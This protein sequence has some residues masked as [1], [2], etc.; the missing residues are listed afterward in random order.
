MSQAAAR[1]PIQEFVQ[2]AAVH[3]RKTE[4]YFGWMILVGVL[5][6]SILS[7]VLI[8]HWVWEFNQP[9]RF[10]LWIGLAA[11]SLWWFF[12]RV[13]PPMRYKI[14]PEYAARQFEL[15][16]PRSKDSLISWIQLNQAANTAPKSVLNFVGRYAFGFLRNSDASQVADNANLIRL[17]AACFGCLLCTMIYFFASPKSGLTSAARML[18]PWANIAPATRVQFANITPGAT[19]IMQGGSLPID[20]TVKG[21]HKNEKVFLRYDLSDGQSRGQTIPLKEEIQGISY[22]LDFGKDLGG[23]HQPLTYWI[24]AGDAVAGP[25]DVG[26]QIV[27]LVAIDHVDLTFPAYTNLKPR[28]IQQQGHFEAPE[29]TIAKIHAIANQEMH[30]A[31]IEFDPVLQNKLFISAR[32]FLDMKV[33]KTQLEATWVATLDRN[34]SIDKKITNYRIHAVNGLKESNHDPVLYQIKVI[35]DLPPEI[36]FSGNAN[37]TIDVPVDQ[38][39]LV[40]LTARDPDYGLTAVEIQG[41]VENKLNPQEPKVLFRELLFQS[42]LENPRTKNSEFVFIPKS[43]QLKPGDQIDLIAVASDNYHN[44]IS[45]KLDP[46]KAASTPMRIRIVESPAVPDNNLNQEKPE[47]SN[48]EPSIAQTENPSPKSRVDWDKFRNKPQQNQNSS[49]SNSR[50]KDPSNANQD[51]SQ[52][53]QSPK[54]GQG[55][56]QSDNLD[57]SRGNSKSP[58]PNSQNSPSN[59]NAQSQ[60]NPSDTNRS[61]GSMPTEDRSALE[62]IQQFMKE[63]PSQDSSNGNSRSN[64]PSE[65]PKDP[66]PNQRN[67]NGSQPNDASGKDNQDMNSSAQDKSDIDKSGADKSGADKTGADKS[68]ADK[69]GADKTGADKTGADKTGADKSGADKSGADKSGADKSGADKSGADKSG[70]DKSGADKSGADKSGADKSG[71]DKS[72][73]DKSGADKSGADKSGADKTGADKTGADKSG[74]DKSGA[75]KSGADKSGMGNSGSKSSSQEDGKQDIGSAKEADSKKE[76]K[77]QESNRNQDPEPVPNQQQGDGKGSGDQKGEKDGQPKSNTP[78][79]AGSGKNTTGKTPQS[80]GQ[81]RGGPSESAEFGSEKANEEYSRKSA[82]M[83][84][85]YI[86]RQRDQPDPELLKRLNWSSDDFRKFADRWRQAK[87]QAKLDPSKKLEL[88]ETLRNLGLTGTGQKVNKLRDRDDGIRGMQEE[89]GRMRPPESLRE[90]FEAFRKAAGKLGK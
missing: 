78:N 17:S 86:D 40:E 79:S 80:S 8:D 68:G 67:S 52:E 84:L 44:P 11:W 13:L 47:N 22:K 19:T 83:L 64:D 61:Q 72:G 21:L 15:Q 50:S 70:A 42:D 69:T 71:A 29:G 53:S 20:V 23:L 45:Q 10:C 59:A 28:S 26:I 63:K 30:T 77:S 74:A 54:S 60:D 75:D 46:Q 51:Q 39:L 2:S 41:T 89:G 55:G 16:D 85:D 36:E 56:I 35:P 34:N 81:D 33:D 65:M 18:M 82:D 57:N 7:F 12:R 58:D 37:L 88:D 66:N 38:E 6:F 49:N 43:H 90:Q 9:V 1:D 62:K 5:L 3:I 14:H 32:E 48:N 87:E 27:P 31:R 73:A 24:H 4:L 25:F 76:Q